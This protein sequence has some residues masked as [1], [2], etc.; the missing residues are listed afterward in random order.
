MSLPIL[1]LVMALFVVFGTAASWKIR[2]ETVSRGAV[3]QSRWPR[4]HSHAALHSL[5]EWPATADQ[6]VAAAAPLAE[7]GDPAIRPPVVSG[8]LPGGIGVNSSLLD[9]RRGVEQ[10]EA[11]ITR[12]PPMMWRM[13]PYGF[14]VEDPL[15]DDKFQYRQMGL[16]SNRQR[17]MP[18]IYELPAPPDA[19]ALAY[20]S[21]VLAIDNAPFTW[22]LRPLDQ[23]DEFIA[24]YGRAPDFHPRM[25]RF[26]S[27]DVPWVD[28]NRVKPLTDRTENLPQRM[29]GAFIRLYDAQLRTNPPPSPAAQSVIQQKIDQLKE[30]QSSLS[31]N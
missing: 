14:D 26:R 16:S 12:R 2:T 15:L 3:W 31:S 18:W 8:P 11:R 20:R 7:L 9:F 30:F 24:F 4:Q 13:G 1:L 21:A 22:Q 23:D 6:S 27:V 29:S 28:K 25:R 17:R 5:A 10:G 19:L